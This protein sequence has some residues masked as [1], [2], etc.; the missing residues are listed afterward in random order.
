MF[1]F[2]DGFDKR[3]A[4]SDTSR[5][6]FPAVSYR[7]AYCDDA[8]LPF[9]KTNMD[10]FSYTVKNQLLPF[11]QPRH[12][13]NL[14]DWGVRRRHGDVCMSPVGLCRRNLETVDVLELL[15]CRPCEY[16]RILDLFY[17]SQRYA[18]VHIALEHLCYLFQV[19]RP[20]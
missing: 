20:S 1:S 10:S 16:R 8:V 15:L 11:R 7:V 12:L 13:I 14:V 19:R 3:D 9:L 5:R 18:R 17:S 4:M 6:L 2:V